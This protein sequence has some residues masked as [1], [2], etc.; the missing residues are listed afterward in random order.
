MTLTEDVTVLLLACC[1]R[2]LSPGAFNLS[3]SLSQILH[4]LVT[5]GYIYRLCHCRVSNEAWKHRNVASGARTPRSYSR[6]CCC[7]REDHFA[8]PCS[9]CSCQCSAS[10]D[11]ERTLWKALLSVQLKMTMCRCYYPNGERSTASCPT[12]CCVYQFPLI[13]CLWLS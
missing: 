3:H 2:N 11:S 4:L 10:T 8:F 5:G 9:C 13:C 7:P 12:V 6:L 1:Y